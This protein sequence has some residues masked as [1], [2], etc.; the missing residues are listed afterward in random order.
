VTT[1][2][3]NISDEVA[4][5][6]ALARRERHFRTLAEAL[7][8]G[9]IETD[10]AGSVLYANARAV[11]ILGLALSDSLADYLQWLTEP[12]RCQVLAQLAL[13]L[14]DRQRREL[15]VGVRLTVGSPSWC[16]ISITAFGDDQNDAV[17]AV[18]SLVDITEIV[19]LRNALTVQATID[20]LTGCNNR[21]STMEI[22]DRALASDNALATMVVFIDLDKFK[23]IN[24]EFG[25]AAGDEFLLEAGRRLRA[26]VR[27][28]DTVGRIGGDEFLIVRQRVTRDDEVTALGLRIK[29]DLERDDVAISGT[30]VA[31]RASIGI[32]VAEEDIGAEELVALA[33]AAM[34]ESKRVAAGTPVRL[35]RGEMSQLTA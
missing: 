29:A 3:S 19:R 28:N 21:A 16:L 13:V 8:S 20:P 25:H 15:E 5:N 26:A 7:P 2:L 23:P 6:D 12:D 14:D 1:Y 31:M 27:S 24:D 17:G 9:V 10:A 32:A 33:D 35:H 34:Y 30:T 11:E 18:L 4:A 22:L